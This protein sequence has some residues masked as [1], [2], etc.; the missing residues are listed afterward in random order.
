MKVKR[1][2][3]RLLSIKI[4]CCSDLRGFGLK[5]FGLVG[6]LSFNAALILFAQRL[7]SSRTRNGAGQPCRAGSGRNCVDWCWPLQL[8]HVERWKWVRRLCPRLLTTPTK[9][10]SL[11]LSPDWRKVGVD[12]EPR[13]VGTGGRSLSPSPSISLLFHLSSLSLS[14]SAIPKVVSTANKIMEDPLNR[15]RQDAFMNSL[16]EVLDSLHSIQSVLGTEIDITLESEE[17]TPPTPHQDHT[18]RG[19]DYSSPDGKGLPAQEQ[20]RAR[21]IGS[22]GSVRGRTRGKEEE[23]E[24]EVRSSRRSS[25]FT[26]VM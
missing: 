6:L 10:H 9:P 19:R 26:L 14:L 24:E 23:E 16:Q 4:S 8:K 5:G 13:G 18:P 3:H 1:M 22:L 15:E 20:K 25:I 7:T 11:P 21:Y 12:M 17:D 2:D